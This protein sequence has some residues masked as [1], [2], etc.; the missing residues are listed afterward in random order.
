MTSCPLASHTQFRKKQVAASDFA[1][2]HMA[3]KPLEFQVSNRACWACGGNFLQTPPVS[4]TSWRAVPLSLPRILSPDRPAR[5]EANHPPARDCFRPS[6]VR[7]STLVRGHKVHPARI[8]ARHLQLQ[9]R[10]EVHARG[11][12]RRPGGL[13]RR[14]QVG[15]R[16]HPAY[17]E[18]RRLL[19]RHHRP[20][21]R[22][23][24]HL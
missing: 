5:H 21:R 16:Q 15:D 6:C 13:L 20:Q 24:R 11:S 14:L 4:Q 23:S 7:Q 1:K 18:R 3:W 10:L 17:D 8:A 19:P 22:R 9:R 12:P 2:R